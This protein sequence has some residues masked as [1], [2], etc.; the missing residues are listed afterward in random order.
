M[1]SNPVSCLSFNALHSH[2]VVNKACTGCQ[3]TQIATDMVCVMPCLKS[4]ARHGKVNAAMT[5]HAQHPVA[6]PRQRLRCGKSRDTHHALGRQACKF[7][8]ACVWRGQSDAVNVAGYRVDQPISQV[9]FRSVRH[10]H[11][12]TQHSL[13]GLRLRRCLMS[14]LPALTESLQLRDVQDQGVKRR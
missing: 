5:Q 2:D 14:V 6:R 9:R 4:T 10:R 1:C 3:C 11:A 7:P 13:R 12:L 8:A